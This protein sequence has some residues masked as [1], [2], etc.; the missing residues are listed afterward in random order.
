MAVRGAAGI[1]PDRLVLCALRDRPAARGVGRRPHA[2]LDP[3]PPVCGHA[4]R[5]DAPEP[6]NPRHDAAEPRR[7]RAAG[8]GHRPA[9]SRRRPPSSGRNSGLAAQ[10]EEHIREARQ[11]ILNLRSPMLEASGLAGALAEIGRRTVAP[12]TNF[13]VSADRITHLRA[14]EGELLRIGQ[15]AITNAAR[16][17]GATHI[18]VELRQDARRHPAARHRRRPGIRRGRDD[19]P[20]AAVTM[21]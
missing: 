6:R 20:P 4:R 13:D 8:P 21:A 9:V 15:E 11:A 7:H 3:E 18:R 10:V 19:C 12:P 2:R 17:A 5:A 14:I 1:P 16:H